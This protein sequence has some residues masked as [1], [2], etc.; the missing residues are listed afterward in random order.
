MDISRLIGGTM[1][2]AIPKRYWQS[3]YPS[4][5]NNQCRLA[6]CS[7]LAVSPDRNILIDAALGHKNLKQI[8]L[9]R[10]D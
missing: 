1:F 6:M 10:M 7:L 2:G 5:D 9:N 4:D 8:T 3:K